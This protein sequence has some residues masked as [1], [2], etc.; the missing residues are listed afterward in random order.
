MF[1][2]VI[3]IVIE[4]PSSTTFSD[5]DTVAKSVLETTLTSYS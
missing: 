1:V 3:G 4:F 5:C 2:I